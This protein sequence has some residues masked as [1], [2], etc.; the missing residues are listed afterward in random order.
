MPRGRIFGASERLC[1]LSTRIHPGGILSMT[2]NR[3]WHSWPV[4][5]PLVT[6]ASTR[7]PR[8]ALSHNR[9]IG[10]PPAA[11]I[12]N[13]VERSRDYQNVVWTEPIQRQFNR[14]IGLRNRV[15]KSSKV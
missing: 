15:N 2:L 14:T 1:D 4:F 8:R 3:S 5:P 13:E 9:V 12:A 10:K 11:D 6:P 7:R